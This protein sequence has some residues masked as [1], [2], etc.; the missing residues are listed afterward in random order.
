[1][2]EDILK[3]KELG[4]KIGYGNLMCIASAIWKKQ[5]TEEYGLPDGAFIPAGKFMV[6]SKYADILFDTTYDEYIKDALN[7]NP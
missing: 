3:V 4:D 1:M 6:K 5:L 7:Q 2:K